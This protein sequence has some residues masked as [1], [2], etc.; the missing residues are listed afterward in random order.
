MPVVSHDT[1]HPSATD[2]PRVRGRRTIRRVT[3]GRS[4]GLSTPSAAICGTRYREVTRCSARV[5]KPSTGRGSAR[6][7]R[8]VTARVLRNGS[9]SEE[10][11]GG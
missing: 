4:R 1:D 8:Q 3:R 6:D 9:A 7:A 2:T 10:D 11:F 5:W